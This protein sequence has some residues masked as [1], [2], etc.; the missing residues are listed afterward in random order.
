ML[1]KLNNLIKEA[2]LNNDLY[3]VDTLCKI[4]MDVSAVQT[5]DYVI[6]Q[7]RSAKTEVSRMKEKLGAIQANQTTANLDA[8]AEDIE[9]KLIAFEMEN[10]LEAVLFTYQF[11]H[12]IART[13]SSLQ[14]IVRVATQ[15]STTDEEILHKIERKTLGMTAGDKKQILYIL[16][17]DHNLNI[18]FEKISRS[19]FNS[20]AKTKEEKE[21]NKKILEEILSE[22]RTLDVEESDRFGPVSSFTSEPAIWSGFALQAPT[23]YKQESQMN[24]W[25]LASNEEK[26]L[27][28]IAKKTK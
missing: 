8:I 4:A 12:K 14:D 19:L 15:D 27:S 1:K 18:P 24:H 21:K 13:E 9:S 6:K 26:I 20:K 7:L 5:N 16:A 25:T 3:L 17:K 11:L 22:Y 28:K 10:P 2:R 23:P